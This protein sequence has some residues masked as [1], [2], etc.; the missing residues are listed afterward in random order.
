SI[1]YDYADAAN[2]FSILHDKYVD[3][4]KKLSEAANLI[5]VCGAEGLTLETSSS[6]MQS[7]ANF[8]IETKHVGK[9]NNGLLAPLPGANGMGQYYLDFTPEMTQDIIANPP[10]VLIVAQADLLLDD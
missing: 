9:P 10:K 6:L 8:L 1:R 7:A 4:N 2:A 5:V 3:Y